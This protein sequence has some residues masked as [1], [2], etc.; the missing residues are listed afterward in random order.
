MCWTTQ[1]SA[2]VL[3]ALA[4]RSRPGARTPG[5][6]VRTRSTGVTSSSRVRIGLI[7]SADP[8][9]A[10]AAP[11]R[12]PL[13]RYSSVSTANHSFS[14]SRACSAGAE[15]LAPEAPRL[16]RARGGEHHQRR[17]AAGGAAVEDVDPLA[18]L[19]LLGQAL[20]APAA[21]TRRCPRSRR[22]GGSR[23]SRRPRR[24]AARR[25][26]RSRRPRAA[27]WCALV[28][29]VEAARRSRRSRAAISISRALLAVEA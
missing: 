16:G 17:A 27:R 21:P 20:A 12:P 9:S 18:A 11:I 15:R 5:A 25:P 10:C 8:S 7:C 26:R 2:P 22:R 4:A 24:A 3:V 19:A 1:A 6:R 28:A 14:V 13:R 29:R 23:R